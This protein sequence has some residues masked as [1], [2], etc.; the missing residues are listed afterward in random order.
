VKIDRHRPDQPAPLWP[1]RPEER[2]SGLFAATACR[3]HQPAG[4]VV[5]DA[6]QVPVAFAVGD[7]IDPDPGEPILSVAGAGGGVHSDDPFDH[8]ADRM[9]IDPLQMRHHALRRG[10][11]KP[12]HVSSKARVTRGAPLTAP[13]ADH[14]AVATMG[15]LDLDDLLTTPLGD[16]GRDDADRVESE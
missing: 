13:R 2:G 14:P 6:H 1:Q 5:G 12:Q 3:P 4:V 16:L 11:N 9:P 8:Y 15:D 7:L 10:P